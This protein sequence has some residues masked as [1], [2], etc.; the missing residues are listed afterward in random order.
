MTVAH[1]T[2]LSA[3]A[4]E[5]GTDILLR[6]PVDNGPIAWAKRNLFSS[7][8]SGVTTILMA[9]VLSWLG[10]RFFD[11]AVLRAVWT[12]P[13]SSI[14]DTQLCRVETAGACWALIQEKYRFILFGLYPYDAQWRPTIC[15]VAFIALYIVS[16]DRRLWG[17]KIAGIWT[18][19][20]AAIFILMRGGVFGLSSVS[21]D[22]WGGLPVTLMLA[23]FGI[24][25]AFPLAILVAMGRTS[26]RNPTVRTLCTLYVELIRGVPL[27]SVLF[28]ASVMFPLFLPE[29]LT[30]SKLLRAQL[31]IVLFVGAYLSETIRGGL[32]AVP[33]GQYDAAKSLGL[34][35]W[36][37][38][39]LVIMPQA[40]TIVLPPIVSLCIAF[41]KNTSL[42]M[43]IGIFDLL[44]AAKRSIGEP[45]WQ[46]FGAE[47]YIFVGVIYF[48][49]CFAMSRYGQR[50][51]KRLNRSR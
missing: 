46:G 34:G 42:V 21:E 8:M 17:W 19:G 29:G 24:A 33:A 20:L 1:Q 48:I 9:L 14:A 18:V 28:M 36:R 11:W 31:G 25:L 43:I 51:E 47:A 12:L 40:L 32:Q 35:Y 13:G 3:N 23:T 44:N 22:L 39:L 2:D 37:M 6:P 38:T 41:F 49:F 50:L 5:A 15:I 10:Y 27:I 7:P 4:T 16:V 30:V 26:E 45:A